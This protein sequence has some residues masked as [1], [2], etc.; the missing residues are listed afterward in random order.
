M[1]DNNGDETRIGRKRTYLSVGEETPRHTA[2]GLSLHRVTG[3]TV[4]RNRQG[5]NEYQKQENYDVL[6][7]DI[8]DKTGHEFSIDLFGCKG[9]RL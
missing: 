2:S 6:T 4:R 1:S 8:I 3:V 5:A 9:V 7:I